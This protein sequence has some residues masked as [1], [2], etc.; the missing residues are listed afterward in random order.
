MECV[1][2]MK[3]NSIL[4]IGETYLADRAIQNLNSIVI[5]IK[6]HVEHPE[7]TDSGRRCGVGSL[8]VLSQRPT[9]C[10]VLAGVFLKRTASGYIKVILDDLIL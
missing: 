2:A 9:D 3:H 5:R 1:T 4:C 7:A 8:E 6:N 10:Y